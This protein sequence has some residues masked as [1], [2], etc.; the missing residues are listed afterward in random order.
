MSCAL[1][2]CA[3]QSLA[4]VA[5]GVLLIAALGPMVDH[6]FPERHPAHGHLYLGAVAQ[7][8]SHPFEHT[9]IHYDALYAPDPG[10]GNVVFFTHNEGSGLGHGDSATATIIESPVFYHEGDSLSQ[11]AGDIAAVLRGVSV[12]PLLQPPK[13]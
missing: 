10:D 6:H 9:H 2:E 4:L 3:T 7:D 11:K 12:A 13:A 8:H 1:K 5:A